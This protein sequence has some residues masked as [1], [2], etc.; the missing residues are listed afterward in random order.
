MDFLFRSHSLNGFAIFCSSFESLDIDAY[1]INEFSH[2]L[3][4]VGKL[5][6]PCGKRRVFIYS[7]PSSFVQNISRRVIVGI[8][9]FL[10]CNCARHRC[11]QY[12]LPCFFIPYVCRG[13]HL[14]IESKV[15]VRNLYLSRL[16]HFI[17]QRELASLWNIVC[18]TKLGMSN[19]PPLDYFPV[20]RCSI[21]RKGM[22]A[23]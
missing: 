6:I 20:G 21:T 3:D 4:L 15:S 11:I 23:P 22:F 8:I 13:I 9:V 1:R 16:F 19:L 14:F 5:W 17:S 10:C 7:A 2:T 18:F 12:F